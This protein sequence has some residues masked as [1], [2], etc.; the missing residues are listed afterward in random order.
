MF[1]S[2]IALGP[3]N[4][5]ADIYVFLQPLINDFKRL[6]VGEWIYDIS[7]KQKFRM[8]A[9]LMWTINDFPAYVML[10]SSST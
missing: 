4:P 10:S 2:C 9:Y 5:K 7:R 3:D 6:W 8:R 1:L